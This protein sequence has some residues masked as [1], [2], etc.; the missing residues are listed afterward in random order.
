MKIKL[1]GI[2]G[3]QFLPTELSP[4]QQAA[5]LNPPLHGDV[6]CTTSLPPS[7]SYKFSPLPICTFSLR[8]LYL[9]RA[10]HWVEV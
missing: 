8:A 6:L 3:T 1:Y 9:S 7:W 2:P 4:K 10:A 5:C